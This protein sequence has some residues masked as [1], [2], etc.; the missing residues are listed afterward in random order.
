MVA[1]RKP[2]TE[3]TVVDPT[4]SCEPRATKSDQPLAPGRLASAMLDWGAQAI[5]KR[6]TCF[7]SRHGTPRA[8][9]RDSCWAGQGVV[10]GGVL[11]VQ[12][13]RWV[14]ERGAIRGVW[15]IVCVCGA[16]LGASR[17][18]EACMPA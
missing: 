18:A 3:H 6:C 2:A 11:C 15:C 9:T 4:P 1:A 10:D 16:V 8:R 12:S 14:A 17:C 5:I 7:K 13:S